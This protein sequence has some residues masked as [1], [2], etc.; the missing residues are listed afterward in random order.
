MHRSLTVLGILIPLAQGPGFAR[1][2]D[3][4][5]GDLFARA[6]KLLLPAK[7]PRTRTAPTPTRADIDTA[8]EL[9]Q[10]SVDLGATVGSLNLLALCR[11]QQ[12]R[13][14]SALAA[15][16]RVTMMAP[17]TKDEAQK[18]MAQLVAAG[19]TVELK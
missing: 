11:S 18:V 10:R 6:V 19:A 7:D 5:A 16:K 8:C 12:E 9:A 4:D 13:H 14:A 2:D 17:K 15:Y 3:G 1:A